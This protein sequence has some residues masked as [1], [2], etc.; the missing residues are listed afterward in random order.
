MRNSCQKGDHPSE[1]CAVS[2]EDSRVESRGFVLVLVLA[3]SFYFILF[4]LCCKLFLWLM[5]SFSY[6]RPMSCRRGILPWLCSPP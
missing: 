1:R 2:Q 6:Q 5:R 3:F 4:M